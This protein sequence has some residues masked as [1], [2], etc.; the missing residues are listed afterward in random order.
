MLVSGSLCTILSSQGEVPSKMASSG[1]LPTMYASRAAGRKYAASKGR[2]KPYLL[3]SMSFALL[4]YVLK[5][6]VRAKPMI[7]GIGR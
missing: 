6:D 2:M 4:T 5:V 7:G 1:M 3:S